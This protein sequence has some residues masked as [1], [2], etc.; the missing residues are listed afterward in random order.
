MEKDMIKTLIR[1]IAAPQLKELKE[2]EEL[3]IKDAWVVVQEFVVIVE[4]NR[5]K[6][7]DTDGEEIGN[8]LA[9]VLNEEIDVDN[10][11]SWLEDNYF[12]FSVQAAVTG[13]NKNFGKRWV[14]K[15]LGDERS[16]SFFDKAGEYTDKAK[17]F[18]TKAKDALFEKGNQLKDK[19]SEWKDSSTK[20]IDDKIS[21]VVK[22]KLD[23]LVDDELEVLIEQKIKKIMDKKD[24]VG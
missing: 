21:V 10:V 3:S 6:F 13:F 12:N 1:E 8:C 14:T 24:A 22:E 15:L 9:E 17:E 4:Q 23:K 19:A 20:Y 18:S 11:P 2:K 7:G 16:E 5:E